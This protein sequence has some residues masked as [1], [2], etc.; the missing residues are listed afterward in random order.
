MANVPGEKDGVDEEG[1][2]D[3]VGVTGVSRDSAMGVDGTG[4]AGVAEPLV[5]SGF[6]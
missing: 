6:E 2:V 5:P 3:G 4:A 1:V